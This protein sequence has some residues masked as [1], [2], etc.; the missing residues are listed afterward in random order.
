V[1]ESLRVT[2]YR[3]GDAI[4]N[5]TSQSTWTGLTTGAYCNFNN[6]T[7]YVPVYGRLYNWHAVNDSRNVAPEGWHVASD[8]DWKQLE[9]YLGMSQ[10][11][12]DSMGWRGTNEGGK[13]KEV[14]TAH[15]D[16]PNT[17]GTNESGFTALASGNR[18]TVDFGNMGTDGHFWTSATYSSSYAWMRSMLYTRAQV[19]CGH[20]I[21]TDGLSVRCIKD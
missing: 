15:W 1:A 8:E 2:H 16:S 19:N 18:S 4:P 13:M 6:N 7:T 21:K 20:Y 10:S 5:V 11:H 3:N 14:G 17:G 12:A 9:M